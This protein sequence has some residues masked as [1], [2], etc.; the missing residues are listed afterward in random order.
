MRTYV[1]V[2]AYGQQVKARR[3]E[4]HLRD[5]DDHVTQFL[6]VRELGPINLRHGDHG[7]DNQA[8]GQVGQ[9]Q[10][11]NQRVGGGTEALVHHNRQ[12]EQTIPWWRIR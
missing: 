5:A 4:E 9:R 6:A 8:H 10:A 2:D 11:H 3:N 7:E 1:S 12:D